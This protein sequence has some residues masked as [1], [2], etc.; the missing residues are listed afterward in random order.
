VSGSEPT[1]RPLPDKVARKL[2]GGLRRLLR[3]TETELV[4][5]V[6]RDRARITAR[7]VEINQRYER[8][9][10]EAAEI[11]AALRRSLQR[12]R[13]SMRPDPIYGAVMLGVRPPR[14]RSMLRFT[15]ARDDLT[16]LGIEVRMQA[17]DVFTISGTSE[18]LAALAAQPATL[19]VRLPRL[20]EPMVEI[21]GAQANIDL[22]HMGPPHVP[23]ALTGSGVIVGLIDTPLDVTHHGFQDPAAP[24][25]S[26]VLY[27]WVQFP[28]SDSAP[29]QTPHQ[30]HAMNL[31]P[32]PDFS[33]PTPLDY[34]RIYTGPAI[35]NAVGSGSPYGDFLFQIS[36][37]P[38]LEEHGTHVAGIA[39]GSGHTNVWTDAPVHVGAAP[40][41]HIVHVATGAYGGMGHDASFEDHVLDAIDFVFRAGDFHGMPAV[42]S[43]SLGTSLGPHNG[44][45]SFD[46]ARDNLVNS[47]DDRVI[48]FGAGNDHDDQSFRRGT[49]AAGGGTEALTVTP[50][51]MTDAPG[52]S[53]IARHR[54]LDLWYSGPELDYQVGCGTASSGWVGPGA[55]YGGTLNGY[56]V[57]VDRDAE[58][59]SGLRNI[60][61]LFRS[62][63]SVDPFTVELRNPAAS[64]DVTYHAWTHGQEASL[65]GA[66]QVD[67][68]LCDTACAKSIISVGACYKRT[69]PSPWIGE[70][71]AAYSGAGPTLDGRV[72]PEIVAVGGGGGRGLVSTNSDQASGYCT[73]YGT[74]MAT[75]LVSGAIALLFEEL[76]GLP[77]PLSMSHDTVK[78]LLARHANRGGVIDP[79]SPDYRPEMRNQYGYGRLRM[80]RLAVE[81]AA[82]VAVGVWIR[83]AEDDWGTEPRLVDRFW[84]S[85]DIR[86]CQAGTT[87]AV[88]ELTWGTTYDV[89]V[90]VRNMGDDDAANA[91]VRLK[92]TRPYAAPS[93]WH[94][95]EDAADRTLLSTVTIPALGDAEV[96]FHWHPESA[97]IGAPPGTTHFCLL[98]E[99][100]HPSDPLVYPAPTTSGGSAW[101]TNIRGTNNVA[102][103][104][105][106]IA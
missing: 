62:A 73:M 59:S 34:G 80:N 96:L 81:L 63:L 48:C 84:R 2:D 32:V 38:E 75:P 33:S 95:A 22:V 39:C 74:S 14:I 105:V 3:M 23:V 24:H 106:F 99:I 1:R 100:D 97:E 41:A 88:R 51:V 52:G 87:T 5:A 101:E 102:L 35:D 47:F 79:A 12:A 43:V 36:C 61:F 82:P 72:K 91:A 86:V 78:A 104:N 94:G 8:S 26:R 31:L 18:Q 42:V 89:R 27:Y 58:T 90:V 54:F 56:D 21:A 83:T 65:D 15:G 10:G 92:Y 49:V 50:T 17:H 44:S 57:E 40:G 16:A 6:R 4:D 103:R 37:T 46:L 71:I 19:R 45:E 29:G 11:R 25:G 30:F 9:V 55:D 28:D 7:L 76:R 67:L 66:T 93:A 60:R 64:G 77:V 13:R 70:T 69:P 68:T 85:P 53:E 98:A 20:L